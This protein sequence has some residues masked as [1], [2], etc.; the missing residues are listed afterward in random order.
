MQITIRQHAF[1]VRSPYSEGTQLTKA[2]AQALNALRAENIRNNMAKAVVAA[3]ALAPDGQVLTAAEHRELQERITEYDLGYQFPL[4]HEARG[5][6]DPIAAELQVVATE[7]AETEMRL[8]G[9]TW[10]RERYNEVVEHYMSK[11]SVQV[12]AR[13]RVA[14]AN[15]AAAKALQDLL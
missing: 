7:L 10:S 5:G 9:G 13:R 2:E 11:A 8:S 1:S 6:Q 3:L 4:R 15:Q 14:L 12:E